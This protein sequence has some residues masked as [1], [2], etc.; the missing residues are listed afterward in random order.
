MGKRAVHKFGKGGRVLQAFQWV[1]RGGRPRTLRPLVMES[2]SRAPAGGILAHAYVYPKR[3]R[4]GQSRLGLD[5]LGA[6]ANL[7][8]G[9]GRG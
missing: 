3:E 7:F 2:L 8:K 4:A 6:R 9:N 1:V 5:G